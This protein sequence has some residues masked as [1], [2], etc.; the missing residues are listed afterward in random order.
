MYQDCLATVHV[1]SRR[2]DVV[3]GRDR[4]QDLHPLRP[5][6]TC[7]LNLYH[8]I[9]SRWY[10]SAGHNTH[11]RTR[12]QRVIGYVARCDFACDRQARGLPIAW[13]TILAE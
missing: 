2:A 8:R 13:L 7:Q 11:G 1:L 9:G 12:F 4:L 6:G 3:S 5:L 10:R